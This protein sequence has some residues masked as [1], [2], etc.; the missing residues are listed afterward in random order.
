MPPACMELE[1]DLHGL[2]LLFDKYK[3]LSETKD[4]SL[5]QTGQLLVNVF[6]FIITNVYG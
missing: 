2:G 5:L 3:F 1:Q 6:S 4:L